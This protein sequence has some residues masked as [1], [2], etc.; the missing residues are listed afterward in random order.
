MRISAPPGAH[1]PTKRW[2]TKPLSRARQQVSRRTIHRIEQVV[3]RLRQDVHDG[4]CRDV[5]PRPT[6]PPGPAKIIPGHPVGHVHLGRDS[7]KVDHGP[8]PRRQGPEGSQHAI[9]RRVLPVPLGQRCLARRVVD[10]RGHGAGQVGGEG[11]Q[12]RHLSKY[13]E[14]ID[15]CSPRLKLP[16]KPGW[17]DAVV[18]EH[19]PA[20]TQDEAPTVIGTVGGGRRRCRRNVA[21]LVPLLA[22]QEEGVRVQHRRVH[23]VGVEGD[24]AGADRR[25]DLLEGAQ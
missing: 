10:E 21:G 5:D 17:H 9:H 4:R 15:K 12:R 3:D 24:E 20:E 2:L 7:S 18:V 25:E 22:V 6:F 16:Q 8:L 23:V 1:S 14:H 19:G 11:R 13:L